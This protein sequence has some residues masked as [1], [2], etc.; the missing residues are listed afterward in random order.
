MTMIQQRKIF[1]QK[2]S[3]R[4]PERRFVMLLRETYSAHVYQKT[5]C[6]GLSA[7]HGVNRL[8][9]VMIRTPNSFLPIKKMNFRV[10]WETN[11]YNLDLPWEKEKMQRKSPA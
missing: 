8:L 2:P 1:P 7:M 10:N 6:P 4:L 3:N 5:G 11:N 9:P